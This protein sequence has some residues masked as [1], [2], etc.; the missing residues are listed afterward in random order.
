VV[1][2][3]WWLAAAPGAAIFLLSIA[4]NSIADGLRAGNSH[5]G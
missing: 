2:D 5:A 4:F 1:F 3:Q